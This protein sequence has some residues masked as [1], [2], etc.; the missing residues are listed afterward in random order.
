VVV[1]QAFREA[2]ARDPERKKRWVVLVDGDRYLVKDRLDI[3]GA[4]WSLEGAEAVPRLRALSGSGDFE[5]YWDFHRKQEYRRNH[6]SK[7]TTG[8][9][10]VLWKSTRYGHLWVVK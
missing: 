4:R 8:R 1:R 7:Y 5:D 6:A 9:H 10:P 3:T 2:L